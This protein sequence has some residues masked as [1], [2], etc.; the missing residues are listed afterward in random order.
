MNDECDDPADGEHIEGEG[1]YANYFNVGHNV[2]EFVLDFGQFYAEQQKPQIHTRIVTSPGYAKIL[3]AL[4]AQAIERY[5]ASFG[6]I[7]SE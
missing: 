7:R 2:F 3:L 1:R 6:V 4:L 5:E